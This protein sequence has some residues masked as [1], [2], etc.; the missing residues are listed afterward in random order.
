MQKKF[1][2]LLILCCVLVPGT[3]LPQSG[4]RVRPASAAAAIF[5]V[6]RQRRKLTCALP[7]VL[8][9][10]PSNPT[11]IVGE[12]GEGCRFDK[13]RLYTYF[14]LGREFE[15]EITSWVG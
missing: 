9:T 7:Q 6:A 5:L 1:V 13:R 4:G 14:Y 8:R 12:R 15:G 2:Q 11:I 10:P 3:S